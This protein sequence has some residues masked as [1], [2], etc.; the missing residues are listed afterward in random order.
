[1][2]I[3]PAGI[4]KVEIMS[5]LRDNYS[6]ITDSEAGVLIRALS[7]DGLVTGNRDAN[8]NGS[9][10][11]VRFWTQPPPTME[12]VIS[13]A[14]IE[15]SDQGNPG[16]DDYGTI[17]GPLV[18]GIQFYIEHDGVETLVGLPLNSNREILQL[19]P[20]QQSVQ[21]AGGVSLALLGFD[22]LT[23]SKS[24]FVLNGNTNDKFGIIVSDDLSTLVAH[25]VSIKGNMR[26]L[27]V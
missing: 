21:F 5:S 13:Q 2:L 22:I 8:V 15:V 6:R 16:I 20:N 14:A 12:Y 24:P 27:N 10:T 23:H 4:I 7:D 1:M 17:A 9:V 26:F 25:T 3:N 18:N 11:S 19:F